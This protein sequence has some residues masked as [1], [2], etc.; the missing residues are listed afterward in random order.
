[1]SVANVDAEAEVDE[2][3]IDWIVVPW[4]EMWVLRFCD[5]AQRGKGFR[6]DGI[7]TR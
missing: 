5:E 7:D 2:A 3:A 4:N 1:M 6:G